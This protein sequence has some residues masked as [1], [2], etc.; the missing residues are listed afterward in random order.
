MDTLVNTH[1]CIMATKFVQLETEEFI[2]SHHK[3]F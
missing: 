3:R 1:I 2:A